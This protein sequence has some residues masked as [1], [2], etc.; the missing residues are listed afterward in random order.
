MWYLWSP[1]SDPGDRS[2][3]FAHNV[4]LGRGGRAEA[5]LGIISVAQP[6]IEIAGS[7][8]CKFN[9]RRL[10][11]A[12]FVDD[13]NEAINRLLRFAGMTVQRS[14]V[15]IFQFEHI[16]HASNEGRPLIRAECRRSF[17]PR[18]LD[19]RHPGLPTLAAG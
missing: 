9:V 12:F 5:I 8:L 18:F 11:V 15:A 14:V 10:G 4:P 1:F 2:F 3:S 16:L 13:L 19:R 7:C 17:A 6:G